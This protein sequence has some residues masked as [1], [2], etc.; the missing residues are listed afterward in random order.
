MSQSG[1]E[2]LVRPYT[3]RLRSYYLAL[4]ATVVLSSLYLTT[5]Q[6]TQFLIVTRL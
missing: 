6:F 5:C 3:L 4:L 2:A 1:L